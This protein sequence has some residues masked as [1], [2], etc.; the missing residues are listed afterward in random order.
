MS[1]ALPTPACPGASRDHARAHRRWQAGQALAQREQWPLAAREFEQ[2]SGLHGDRAYAL[3]AVHALIKSGRMA[4]AVER[5][6]A[7][8]EADPQA[9]L[10]YTLESHALLGLGRPAT[11]VDCLQAMPAGLARD[12]AHHVSMAVALQRCGRHEDAIRSFFDGLALKMDDA[13][14]HFRLGMSFKDLGLK[15]EAAE[16]VRTAVVLGLGGGDLG[17]RGQLAFLE[18]EACRWSHAE[19]VLQGLRDAVRTVPSDQPNETSP[20]SHAVLVDDPL[21]QLKVSRHYALHV[22]ALYP[23]LPRRAA[24]AHG[25]R[26]RI[27]YLSADFHQHATAQ[28]MAQMLECHDRSAFEVTLLSAGPRADGPLRRRLRAGSERFEELSGQPFEAMARRIRELG[29]DLLVDLKGATHDT[30]MAVLAQRPAPLQATWLG[31]PE[32]RPARRSI[33]YLIGDPVVTPIADA[34]HF[35][36]KI[37][38]LPHCYQPNDAHRVRPQPSTRADW[39]VADGSLL[40]CGFHQ[41]YKISAA[42]MD[43]WCRLCTSCPAPCSGCCSGTPTCRRH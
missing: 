26:L 1:L 5:A 7:L 32:T 34:A 3:A 8:R 13:L 27:G 20:F 10:A 2:A 30:L 28:L 24:R 37:A 29:I 16:C 40:L 43:E 9:A 25:G 23:A 39:G 36:E 31:F 14:S 33:D 19:A 21:E 4:E 42:V 12:H 35:S 6:R 18:R 22:A 38:Q 17:A 11:A 15:A 41:S